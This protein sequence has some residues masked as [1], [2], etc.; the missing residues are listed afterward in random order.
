[1]SQYS[2][3][4]SFTDMN[5]GTYLIEVDLEGGSGRASITSPCELYVDGGNATASIEWSSPNYDYMIVDDETYYPVNEEGNSVFEIPVA[6]LDEP[7]SVTADTTAMSVPHEIEYTLTFDSDSMEMSA[8][9]GQMH[10]WLILLPIILALLIIG[11]IA[12]KRKS[13]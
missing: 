3:D 4:M 6:A 5:D 10:Y 12:K 2:D 8:E 1:M 13:S 7:I 11:A 9:E